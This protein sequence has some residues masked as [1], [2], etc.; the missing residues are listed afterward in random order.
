[1]ASQRRLAEERIRNAMAVWKDDLAGQSFD[2]TVF[3][4]E[5]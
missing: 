5:P 2:L 4:R 1:M 3:T